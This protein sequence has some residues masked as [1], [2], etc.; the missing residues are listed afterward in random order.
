MF[1]SYFIYDAEP[2]PI[3]VFKVEPD[4]STMSNVEELFIMFPVTAFVAPV[5]NIVPVSFGMVIVLSAVGSTTVTVVS[6]A[7]AVA[8]SN[9]IDDPVEVIEPQVKLPELKVP[10]VDRFSSPKLIEPELSVIDPAATAQVPAFNVVPLTVVV[11]SVV[12]VAEVC[13]PP[14][15]PLIVGAV[16]VTTVAVALMPLDRELASPNFVYISE[17]LSLIFAPPAFKVSPLPS[18]AF[19]PTPND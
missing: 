5:V 6:N 17:K 15:T 4:E 9:I 1:S 12:I 10:V 18:L 14:T 13:V 2:A 19:V 16:N 8:P 3:I 11:A 7:S